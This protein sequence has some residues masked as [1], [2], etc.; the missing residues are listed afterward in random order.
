MIKKSSIFYYNWLEMIQWTVCQPITLQYN[1][2]MEIMTELSHW[3][4]LLVI[5][6]D[7][8]KFYLYLF[9]GTH[10]CRRVFIVMILAL[11]IVKW[12]FNKFNHNWW[13][14]LQSI[15]EVTDKDQTQEYYSVYSTVF[16]VVI[17]VQVD[18]YFKGSSLNERTWWRL[19]HTHIA[20]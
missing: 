19:F 16:L 12:I 1:W 20:K 9:S 5:M 14:P 8:Q 7:H 13:H 3:V 2:L 11:R 4:Q 15:F 17:T 6:I 10:S 18:S